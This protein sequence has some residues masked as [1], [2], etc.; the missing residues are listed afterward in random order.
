VPSVS[1][2]AARRGNVLV[3]GSTTS[4]V[5]GLTWG[6]IQYPWSSAHVLS[7]LII[8]LIGLGIFIIYETYLCK[9]PVV[10]HLKYETVV[11]LIILLKV[12][13]VVRMNWTGTSA[14]L[15]NFIV[16]IV[17]STVCCK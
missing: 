2:L 17:A 12:P 15:Q 11:D 8:G 16:A 4:I 1:L 14:Y 3:I 10:S 6:G 13:I 9:P 7:P 5:I